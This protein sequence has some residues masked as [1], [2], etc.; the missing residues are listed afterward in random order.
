VSKRV[1]T[2]RGFV[3]GAALLGTLAF[4]ACA[5]GI[6]TGYGDSSAG[7]MGSADVDPNTPRV[8]RIGQAKASDGLDMT[9]TRSA[10]SAAIANAIFEP[11]VR[12]NADGD[13]EPVLLTEVPSFTDDGLTLACT[14][15]EGVTFHDGVE[16]TSADVKYTFERMMDPDVGATCS[17][18]F[19]SITGA[20]KMLSGKA[21]SLARGITCED[22]THVTFHLDEPDAAFLG[23][24]ATCHAHIF[25]QKSCET[26]GDTWG[27]G[28]Y[29]IG[30][31]PYVITYN[32]GTNE[33]D[34]APYDEYHGGEPA[35]DEIRFVYFDD[36]I[37]EIKAFAD[38][39]IDYCA[40]DEETLDEYGQVVD[41][42][43]E[44]MPVVGLPALGVQYIALNR[45]EGSLLADTRVRQALSLAVDREAL[46]KAISAGFGTPATGLIPP[47]LP[48]YVDASDVIM[49]DAVRAREL[50]AEVEADRAAA[51]EDAAAEKAEK[52]K[53]EDKDA[54]GEADEA[55]KDAEADDAA[56]DEDADGDD[57]AAATDTAGDLTI[58]VTVRTERAQA[59]MNAV[60]EY[61][62]AIG[63]TVEVNAVGGKTWSK[64]LEAGDVLVTQSSA[65]AQWPD[66]A[67]LL[68]DFRCPDADDDED[69]AAT[70]DVDDADE[71]AEKGDDK[72]AKADDA[73]KGDDADGEDA[74]PDGDADGEDA[75]DADTAD[76]ETFTSPFDGG[77][78]VTELLNQ[79]AQELDADARAQALAEADAQLTRTDWSVIPLFWP[80]DVALTMDYVTN[81]RNDGR[82]CVVGDLDVD[83]TQPD[84]DPDA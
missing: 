14:L 42:D 54:G 67:Q 64:E 61:W 1:L 12:F 44:D 25:P 82:A 81:L 8:L 10:D 58:T 20:S 24:L 73:E 79:A 69:E 48:G 39:G 27:K 63:L 55:E 31:G 35:L 53:D 68:E 7:S 43:V 9:K 50:L 33:V 70:T 2:R 77:R 83:I 22:D 47:E 29:C 41:D 62:E 17:D 75:A 19:A 23:N 46:V 28:T 18:M 76:A 49:H 26:A 84:Y 65:Y 30:T 52:D 66:A 45:A 38:G 37:E 71:D 5:S 40:V 4:D 15:K 60:A 21:T 56:A 34:L 3:G 51:A 74:D 11:L 32:D 16:L 72:D 57:A 78:Y 36:D 6:N 13:L 80:Q 59:I